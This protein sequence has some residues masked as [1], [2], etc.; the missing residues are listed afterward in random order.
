MESKVRELLV[1]LVKRTPLTR[2]NI[3][4]LIL[5]RGFE[6]KNIIN[7]IEKKVVAKKK[8]IVDTVMRGNGVKSK[9]IIGNISEEYIIKE[10]K[11]FYH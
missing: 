11:K 3:P 1:I 10:G 6:R 5:W 7:I 9:G 2:K 4:T 8:N